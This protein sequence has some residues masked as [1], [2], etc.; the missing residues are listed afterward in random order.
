MLTATRLSFLGSSGWLGSTQSSRRP[1]PLASRMNGVQPCDLASSPVSSS[2]LRFSQPA[3]PAPPTPLEVHSV[4]PASSARIRWCVG[5]QVEISVHLP[6]AGSYIDRCRDELASGN[7]RAEGWLEPFLQKSGLLGWRTR[8]VAHTR[9]LSSI[10]W[11]CVLVWLSQIGSGPQYG[12]GAIGSARCEG[13][14]GSR[15]GCF[16]SVA[17]CFIGSSTGQRSVLF[18]GAP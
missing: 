5:K 6:E 17:A 9:P 8:A 10:I 2:I 18:S 4:P 13:V 15:T 7:T 1:L 14:F 12:D 11:L 16:T 3:T